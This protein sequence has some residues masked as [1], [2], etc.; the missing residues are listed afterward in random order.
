MTATLDGRAATGFNRR[1]TEEA[2][3]AARD[4]VAPRMRSPAAMRALAEAAI[5]CRDAE[6]AH[7]ARPKELN[8]RDGPDPVRYGDWEVAGRASDF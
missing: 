8:G 1:M 4:P 6:R 7:V 5:R 2:D 3:T